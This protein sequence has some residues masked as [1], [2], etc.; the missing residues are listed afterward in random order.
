MVVMAL[1]VC[2]VV[3]MGCLIMSF[4]NM[5]HKHPVDNIPDL[6]T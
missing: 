5:S 3:F 6:P 4:A 2:A 1:L